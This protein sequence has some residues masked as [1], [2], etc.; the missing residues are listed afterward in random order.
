MGIV[1]FK[2]ASNQL[3]KANYV[4]SMEARKGED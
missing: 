1:P 2:Q 4:F 3:T